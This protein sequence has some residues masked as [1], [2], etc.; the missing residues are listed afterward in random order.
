M[1]KLSDISLF[2]DSI[3]PDK[4]LGWRYENNVT[5]IIGEHQAPNG[6]GLKESI[7]EWFNIYLGNNE[8]KQINF[9]VRWSFQHLYFE[10]IHPFDDGN[11]RTA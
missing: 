1:I 8:Y 6:I 2:H 4:A 10:T 9:L 7:E 11:G 3:E 5:Q